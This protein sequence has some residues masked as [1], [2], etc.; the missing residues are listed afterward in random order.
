MRMVQ[1][2]LRSRD[3]RD[4]AVL[5]AMSRVPRHRFVGRIDLEAAY[6]DRALPTLEGQTISQPY[7]VGIMTQLLQ[8][9]PGH[10]VLEIGTGSGYQAA[11]LAEMRAKVISI[12]RIASL[13]RAAEQRLVSLGYGDRVT[14]VQGDGSV[15]IRALLDL[16]MPDE[17]GAEP[18]QPF[19]RILVTAGAPSFSDEL[20]AQ[21]ADPGRAVVPIGSRA[22]QVLHVYELRDGTLSETTC[23]PCRFVPLIGERGWA[24]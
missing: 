16:S 9:R 10:R 3:I 11:I 14:V 15:G 2:Q 18:P 6:A 1:A 8:V 23:V 7:M 17:G 5:E 19:D 20:L 4:E 22:E 13:A 12:E 24:D 21:L